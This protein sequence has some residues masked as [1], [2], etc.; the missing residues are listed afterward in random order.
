MQPFSSSIPNWLQSRGVAYR[1]EALDHFLPNL[2]CW[3][4]NEIE[5]IRFHLAHE[6]NRIQYL[7]S[8]EPVNRRH[9]HLVILQ[10]LVRDIDHWDRETL[11]PCL[12]LPFQIN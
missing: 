2:S 10:R 8:S 5:A 3:E 6:V 4:H 7:L 9:L 11:G 1:P 12:G